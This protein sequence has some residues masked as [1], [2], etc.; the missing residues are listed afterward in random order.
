MMGKSKTSK[1]Y[2]NFNSDT[3]RQGIVITVIHVLTILDELLLSSDNK[4]NLA[5]TVTA[6]KFKLRYNYS[7]LV[8]IT[9][10]NHSIF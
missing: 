4:H 8:T 9:N 2:L 10:K 5:H 1:N 6:K 7:E 3:V